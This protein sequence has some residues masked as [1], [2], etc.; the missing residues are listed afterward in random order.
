MEL[1]YILWDQHAIDFLTKWLLRDRFKACHDGVGLKHGGLAV[2]FD[3][4]I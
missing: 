2:E 1:W 4:R 3:A